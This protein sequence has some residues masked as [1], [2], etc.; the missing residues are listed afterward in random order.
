MMIRPGKSS[1]RVF[2]RRM[3]EEPTKRTASFGG[4]LVRS[5]RSK[6]S[7]SAAKGEAAGR[8]AGAVVADVVVDAD[9]FDGV[10]FVW[11]AAGAGWAQPRSKSRAAFS[12]AATIDRSGDG[13]FIS[14][15]IRGG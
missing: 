1:F 5:E 11:R 14:V 2:Q 4:G 8:V 9:D 15:G 13:G 7:I 10:G 6:A 3:L 12:N